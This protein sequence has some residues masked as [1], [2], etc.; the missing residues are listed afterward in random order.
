M[1]EE[2]ILLKSE[3]GSLKPVDFNAKM[4][5]IISNSEPIGTYTG[6]HAA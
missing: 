5:A 6:H 1:R 3:T 4:A 2:T